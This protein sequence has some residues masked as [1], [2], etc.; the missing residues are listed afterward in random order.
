MRVYNLEIFTPK[1]V[2]KDHETITIDKFVDDYLSPEESIIEAS[3]SVDVA[4]GDY[5]RLSDEINGVV[6]NL[7]R[8]HAWET[9]I[10]F[11]PFSSLFSIDIM[12]DTRWQRQGTLEGRM[13]QI[14]TDYLISNADTEQNVLG[15]S[16]STTSETTDWGFNLKALTEGTNKLIINFYDTIMQRALLEYGVAVSVKANFQ[17]KTITVVIGNVPYTEKVIE[18]DLPNIISA[19]ISLDEREFAINKLV[20]YDTETLSQVITYYLHPDGTYDT[21]NTDRVTPV[22]YSIEAIYTE[23]SDFSKSAS[24]R[25]REIFGFEKIN[26]LIEIETKLDDDIVR[27]DLM[28]IGQEV[29]VLSNGKLYTSVVTGKVVAETS[30]IILGGVRLELTKRL[31]GKLWQN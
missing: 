29:S 19:N 10:Y 2:L 11:K 18:A 14:I 22:E 3:A 28:K 5:V 25:A 20:M 16:V 8:D 12:F 1:F 21:N 24:D 27:P 13:A 31:G 30:T 4:V 15:L 7:D 9:L 26:N 17:N 6:T 23:D